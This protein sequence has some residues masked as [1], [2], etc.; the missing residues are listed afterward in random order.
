[1]KNRLSVEYQYIEVERTYPYNGGKEQTFR[2]ELHM[3]LQNGAWITRQ[4]T[5]LVPRDA[6]WCVVGRLAHEAMRKPPNRR[7]PWR[8]QACKYTQVYRKDSNEFIYDFSLRDEALDW[9]LKHYHKES[10]LN[11]YFFQKLLKAVY[12]IYVGET[13]AIMDARFAADVMSFDEFSKCAVGEQNRIHF[14]I[15]TGNEECAVE[16]YADPNT[17]LL[18]AHMADGRLYRAVQFDSEKDMLEII[19]GL[20]PNELYALIDLGGDSDETDFWQGKSIIKYT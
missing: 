12:N 8:A 17:L 10:N 19:E 2:V 7:Y 13:N 3:Q 5:I 9:E 18:V 15:Y 4:T 14:C 20:A 1:M 16:Y 11:T 6:P